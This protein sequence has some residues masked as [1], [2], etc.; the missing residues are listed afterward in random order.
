[1]MTLDGV[2][3]NVRV[4]GPTFERLRQL[5]ANVTRPEISLSIVT[6]KAPELS[7]QIK[8]EF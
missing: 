8:R 4:A 6:F 2:T 7:L 5:P 3:L 1:M